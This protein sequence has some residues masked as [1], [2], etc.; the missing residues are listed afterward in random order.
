MNKIILDCNE[1]LDYLPLDAENLE[2]IISL[3][4]EDFQK[5]NLV[6]DFDFVAEKLREA[7]ALIGGDGLS[8]L[9]LKHLIVIAVNDFTKS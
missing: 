7:F 9:F 8:N 3:I 6:Y 1:V 2:K 4:V 5:E